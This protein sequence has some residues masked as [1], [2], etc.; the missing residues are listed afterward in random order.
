MIFNLDQHASKSNTLIQDVD[1]AALKLTKMKI[2][3]KKFRNFDQY[4]VVFIN[5]FR[6]IKKLDEDKKKYNI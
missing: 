4:E 2:Y 3:K 6:R 1:P 5:N